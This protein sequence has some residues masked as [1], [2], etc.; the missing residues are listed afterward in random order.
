MAKPSTPHISRTWNRLMYILTKC[1]SLLFFS[2]NWPAARMV[3]FSMLGF[4]SFIPLSFHHSIWSPLFLLCYF[5][6]FFF[7]T[8]C[9]S[10][11]PHTLMIPNLQF[12]TAVCVSFQHASHSMKFY[13]ISS[14]SSLSYLVT[15]LSLFSLLF[16]FNILL[17]S[18]FLIPQS[19]AYPEQVFQFQSVLCLPSFWQ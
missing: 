3:S 1:F 19:D 8:R 5:S 7:F 11:P 10:S 6:A 9:Y 12:K 2:L 13:H 14:L 4:L 17:T 15:F 18:V 16:I